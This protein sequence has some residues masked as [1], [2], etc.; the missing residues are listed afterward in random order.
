MAGVA[1]VQMNSLNLVK[2]AASG[3]FWLC[4]TLYVFLRPAQASMNKLLAPLIK[5]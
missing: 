5:G 3:E 1:C 2:P 4:H